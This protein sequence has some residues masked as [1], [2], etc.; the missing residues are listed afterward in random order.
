MSVLPERLRGKVS[1][2]T[3]FALGDT[4][5]MRFGGMVLAM[6]DEEQTSVQKSLLREDTQRYEAY[7]ESDYYLSDTV[8]LTTRIYDHYYERE[9]TEYSGLLDV[10][11]NPE[12]ENENLLSTDC[13]ATI[14]INEGLL[15]SCGAEASLNTMEREWLVLEDL[16]KEAS[17][18]RGAL[19]LQGEWYK[20]EVY[21]LVAGVRSEADTEY[22]F[23]A[24]PRLAGMYHISPEIR[25]LSGVG[26]GYRAPDFNELYLYRRGSPS[27]PVISGNPDLKPEYSLGGNLGAEYTTERYF[28]HAN[29]YYTELYQE[30]IN[31]E[32]GD[33]DPENGNDIYTCGNL[34]RS[35]RA[36]ADL[37]GK[38]TLPLKTFVSSGYS[39]LF[40]YDRSNSE[41][42]REEPQHT[43]RIKT[44]ID[45]VDQQFH[46]DVSENF[47][48][49]IDP[50]DD[51]KDYQEHRYQIDLYSSWGVTKNYM[52]FLSLENV[53]GYI[54]ESLGPY[55]GQKLTLGMEASF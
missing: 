14:D 22:G 40:A 47:M 32:T 11:E 23:I 31:T 52:L 34:N 16:D 41:E 20:E 51:D 29:I 26:L 37:E 7:L 42:L 43:I 6:R 45:L 44:G 27:H 4:F 54:N 38:I 46:F 28:I 12:Y 21:S 36:G 39:Y 10:W 50:E 3:A 8:S 53:T 1:A 13:F 55:Y 25:L 2:E 15:V 24:A 30:I 17:R 48:S 5:D 35:L 18:W 9:R 19:V 33:T 49:A